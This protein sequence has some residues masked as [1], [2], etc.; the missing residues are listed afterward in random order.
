[1]P[2]GVD[3][4]VSG[5][6]SGVDWKS[7]V[8][9]LANA[10]RSP[11]ILWHNNQ[12]KINNK[13]STFDRIKTFL[14][15][16]QTDVKALKEPLVFA[17]RL[18]TT[19]DA[20]TA[21]ASAGTAATAGTFAFNI[22]QLATAARI[23]GTSD[24]GK[25]IS[26]TGDLTAV[27]V[28]NAG[29]STTVSAGTFTVNGKQITLATTDTLQ[30]VLGKIATATANNVTGSYNNVTDKF[31]LTSA[32][33]SEIILG[34]AT[35]TSNFLQV[36]Q[37]YNNGTG[38]I[39][40]A[41]AL[42]R[43]R[44]T[45][46]LSTANLTTAITDGGSGAGQF[47]INGVAINYNATTDSLQNIL[48]RITNSAA[49][50]TASYDSQN[51]RFL[52]A[53]KVSGD[54]GISVADVTG[55]FIAATGLTGGA[56][57]HGQ[58]LHY[59]LNGGTQTLVSSSNTIT[60]DSSGIEG[61]TVNALTTGAVT[62][63][64]GNDT[65]KI[66]TALETFI[67]DY[68]TVQTYISTQTTSSTDSTGHVTAG[69]LAS[70]PDTNGIVNSLRSLSFS[71]VTGLTGAITQLAH[72]GIDTN[73]KDNTIALGNATTLDNALANNLNQVQNL[74]TDA[75][76]G[77]GVQLDNYFT[78]TIGDAGTL[79]NHMTSLTKQI[80][81]IDAQIAS[82]EKTVASD[83]A[84]WTKA[85]RA[86]ETAQSQINQQLSYLNQAITKGSL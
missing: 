60:S 65:S 7:V 61:V 50:V 51:D 58:N 22:S 9:Q 8:L 59:T 67:K 13:N 78:K 18:A 53:N 43:A 30:Q 45:G 77:L 19:S 2:V 69:I 73:G 81:S 52:L 44:L 71:P 48:D 16:L 74:F 24:I 66:K 70:D 40:S 41:A 79:T 39:T 49:G 6:A 34:S 12:V 21:S 3:L 10:E 26:P 35:D 68:N 62:V 54:V 11:E 56:F 80:S 57:A 85:F 33:N 63:T 75:T 1:M 17:S 46:T 38:T 4:S 86:M 29:F 5:L 31:T 37:L 23:N 15:A 27:T 14:T 47:N 72:L 76:N 28:A 20:A 83:S 25:P 84:H 42:G 64:V 55:N 82:L 32:T 36:A